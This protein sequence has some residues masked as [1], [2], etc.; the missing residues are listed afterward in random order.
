MRL[1]PIRLMVSLLLFNVSGS[2]Q[3]VQQ[4]TTLS[5][6]PKDPQAVSVL[7]QTLSAAG[8]IT[9]IQSLADY[10]AT[11]NITYHWNPEEQGTVTVV[12][13][14]VDQIRLD[15]NLSRG[16]YSSVI[17]AGQSSTKTEDGELTRYPPP[18]RVPSS[19]AYQY[20]PPMFPAS[21]VVPHMQ[22]ATIVNNPRY[23]ISYKG[24]VQLDS[25][26]VYDV[27]VQRVLPGQTQPDSMAE[28][29]T[30]ELFIDANTLHVVMTE[31]NVPKHIVHQ[32]RY[33]D[34]RS[35]NGVLI[36]FSISEQMSGQ[37]TREIQLTQ[38]NFN[39][40]LQNAAFALQ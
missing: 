27:L 10:T 14:G 4:A 23:G 30:I 20:Q 39:T 19:D 34:Y 9:A 12:G 11:G 36:P 35:V 38:F 18:Y 26:S 6:A 1:A 22:L 32:I 13:L 24:I 3:T 7:N 37:K 21:L 17:S 29:H 8:G 5:P 15:A 31:D 16:I 40:G 28:Y 25:G 33:S 2:A